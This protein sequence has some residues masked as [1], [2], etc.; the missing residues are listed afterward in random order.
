MPLDKLA[1]SVLPPVIIQAF[2]YSWNSIEDKIYLVFKFES[3]DSIDGLN[4][5]VEIF[6]LRVRLSNE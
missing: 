5:R 6:P 1:D 3:E 2:L 4:E